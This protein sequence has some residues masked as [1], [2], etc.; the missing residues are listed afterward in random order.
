M[1]WSGLRDARHAKPVRAPPHGGEFRLL[2]PSFTNPRRRPDLSTSLAG[3]AGAHAA[4][5]DP[6]AC[7]S[8]WHLSS[9]ECWRCASVE[10]AHA[11]P[12]FGDGLSGI[13]P[14]NG[15]LPNFGRVPCKMPDYPSTQGAGVSGCDPRGRSGEPLVGGI[16]RVLATSKP[17]VSP[18]SVLEVS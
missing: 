6:P 5:R 9:G 17:V 18:I 3:Q 13:R 15:G 14:V 16:W 7:L 1:G 10:R 4:R 12:R 8:A 11:E 2:Q